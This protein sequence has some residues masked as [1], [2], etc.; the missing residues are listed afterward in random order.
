M[1]IPLLLACATEPTPLPGGW[2]EV[3]CARPN[4]DGDFVVDAE[5]GPLIVFTGIETETESIWHQQPSADGDVTVDE[6]GTVL[7]S[8]YDHDCRA[9]AWR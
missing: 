4:A 8:S 6:S 3:D 7:V 5:L 1:L 9:W 2:Y